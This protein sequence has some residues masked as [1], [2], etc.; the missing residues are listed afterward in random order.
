VG[1]P[2]TLLLTIDPTAQLAALAQ[3]QE[4]IHQ[5]L[6]EITPT[7]D[8]DLQALWQ[9]QAEQLLDPDA[10]PADS[11][12]RGSP[13]PALPE[14]FLVLVTCRDEMDQVELLARLKEEG[15]EC[16]ALLA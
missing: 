5:R 12:G 11:A 8:P 1:I 16:K 3:T 13:D 7:N 9:A 2:A 10:G 4:Q 6:Q 15:R 14:Q